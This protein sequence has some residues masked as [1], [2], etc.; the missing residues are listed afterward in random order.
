[1]EKKK[2]INLENMLEPLYILTLGKWYL[3]N[4]LFPRFIQY[5]FEIKVDMRLK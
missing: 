4:S 5:K 3:V 2:L 1:M